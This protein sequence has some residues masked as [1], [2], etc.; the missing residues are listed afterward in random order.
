MDSF[1]LMMKEEMLF[2]LMI[3]ILV[4]LF[5]LLLCGIWR[6]MEQMRR[7]KRR[8]ADYESR[9]SA[10]EPE[11]VVLSR[12][13]E[14]DA[15][16]SYVEEHAAFIR[17]LRRAVPTLTRG[18]ERLCVLIRARKR[19][20][21]IARLLGIDESSL[22]TLRYRLKRKLPLPEGAALDD[23]ILGLGKEDIDT[24]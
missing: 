23:W 6:V 7:V 11:E 24:R 15:A 17:D 8:K 22:Y 21:E 3:G 2:Y 9:V 20:R 13:V 5:S 10:A 16:D 12:A 19:N 14:A 1:A 18:E 4:A